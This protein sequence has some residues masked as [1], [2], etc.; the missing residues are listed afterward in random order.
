MPPTGAPLGTPPAAL[1]S[2][3]RRGAFHA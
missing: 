3:L 1:A 2:G